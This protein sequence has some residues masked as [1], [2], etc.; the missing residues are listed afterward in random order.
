MCFNCVISL[1]ILNKLLMFR[2]P[3]FFF[4]VGHPSK[5][6]LDAAAEAPRLQEVEILVILPEIG[7]FLVSCIIF[8]GDWDVTMLG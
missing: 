7:I 8:C 5:V 2:S 3:F 4:R 1:F 6:P